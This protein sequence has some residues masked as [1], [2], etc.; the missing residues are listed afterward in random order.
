M[1]AYSDWGPS[2]DFFKVLI[3]MGSGGGLVGRA[4]AF[5]TRDLRFESQHWQIIYLLICQLHDLKKTTIKIKRP[6][7]PVKKI[8]VLP[9][10]HSF[11][12]GI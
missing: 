10:H 3:H 11:K 4:V 1:V 9:G 12:P 6:K 8:S 2:L 5:N 7:W